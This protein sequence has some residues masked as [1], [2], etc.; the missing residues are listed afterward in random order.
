MHG[1]HKVHGV[2]RGPEFT[3]EDKNSEKVEKTQKMGINI[4]GGIMAD[5][6][7]KNV[8]R[9]ATSTKVKRFSSKG[10]KIFNKKRKIF[11]KMQNWKI[12]QQMQKICQQ[13]I[14]EFSTNGR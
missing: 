4:K 1:V 12:F 10:R 13:K 3:Y 14:E 5:N 2:L 7:N 6:N 9:E 8:K 11:N